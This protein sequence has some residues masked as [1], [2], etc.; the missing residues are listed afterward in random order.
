MGLHWG[1]ILHLH[2]DAIVTI[3][4]IKKLARTARYIS[5]C[6]Y[7]WTESGEYTRYVPYVYL[8]WGSRSRS[9]YSGD[10]RSSALGEERVEGIDCGLSLANYIL[11][12]TD[13]YI[14]S[15]M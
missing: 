11:P 5:K 2:R 9:R 6:E 12:D 3:D 4:K 8:C 1:A 7:F 14:P 15:T 10:S 13:V